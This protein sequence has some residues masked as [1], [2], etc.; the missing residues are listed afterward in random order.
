[1]LSGASAATL[2][3]A[4]PYKHKSAFGACYYRFSKDR[5][6]PPPPD[7]AF[8]VFS[9][10]ADSSELGPGSLGLR[11]TV[12]AYCRPWLFFAWILY[13]NKASVMS[14]A[15]YSCHCLAKAHRRIL[16]EIFRAR[17]FTYSHCSRFFT[18]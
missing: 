7:I 1:M 10:R 4:H 3:Q 16:K 12:G 14:I 9:G 11:S 18:S 17:K 5:I 2:Y 8:V 15:V 13:T 6:H